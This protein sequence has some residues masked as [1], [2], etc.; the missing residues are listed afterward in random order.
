MNPY[1]RSPRT[2]AIW[3]ALML[4][5]VFPV[6]AGGFILT[7]NAIVQSGHHSVLAMLGMAVWGIIALG[8][9]FIGFAWILIAAF[10]RWKLR[11]SGPVTTLS[12][13]PG[14]RAE[15]AEVLRDVVRHR[16]EKSHHTGSGDQQASVEQTD[17]AA[18]S[19]YNR[20]GPAQIA[21]DDSSVARLDT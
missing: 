5:I 10:M 16:D 6:V 9:L 15:R 3:G 7:A 11:Q 1:L 4:W 21:F 20:T 8:I 13:E 19:T 2:V 18:P 12:P 17:D 14:D